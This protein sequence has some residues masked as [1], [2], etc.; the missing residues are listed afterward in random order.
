MF[1]YP[2][3]VDH[4]KADGPQGFSELR[5]GENVFKQTYALTS[6]ENLLNDVT[7]LSIQLSVS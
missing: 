6:K 5:L 3:F 7:K 4:I 1:I 2:I